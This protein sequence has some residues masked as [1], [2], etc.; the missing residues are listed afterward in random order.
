MKKIFRKLCA[1]LYRMIY[2]QIAYSSK[3]GVKFGNNCRLV[4]KVDFGS[5]PFLIKL[6][7]HVSITSSNFVTHDGGVW[8]MRNEYPDIDVFSPIIVGNNVFIGLGCTILPGTIIGDN[9]VIG[10]GSLVK[11]VIDSNSVYAG[12]PAK[13]LK[14]VDEY[15]KQ[16]LKVGMN[17]KN[18]PNKKEILLNAFFIE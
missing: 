8:I 7:D 17:T 1:Y 10:A 9:V 13:K 16:C 4:G 5:E 15:K 14:N 6:G 12:I 18:D 3:L 2:G 11:G